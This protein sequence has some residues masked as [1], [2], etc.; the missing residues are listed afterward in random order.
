MGLL[1]AIQVVARG[2]RRVLPPGRLAPGDPV[3]QGHRTGHGHHPTV[4]PEVE[5]AQVGRVVAQ[6]RPVPAGEL[7]GNLVSVALEADLALVG[8]LP[9]GPLPEG[10]LEHLGGDGTMHGALETL[11]RGLP[12]PRVRGRVISGQP[13]HQEPV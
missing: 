12:S 9:G 8:D 6:D 1:Q 11:G 7:Q 13:G 3:Q 10:L 5:P 2:L 4:L